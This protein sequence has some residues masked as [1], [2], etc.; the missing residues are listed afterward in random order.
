[1]S[2]LHKPP[3]KSPPSRDPLAQRRAIVEATFAVCAESG[4]PEA[5]VAEIAQRAGGGIDGF[6]ASFADK[7]QA[8][9]EL[10]SIEEGRLLGRVEG[11]CVGVDDPASR[12]ERGL[13]AVL[14]WV[15]D[16]PRDA[17]VCIVESTRATRRIFERR[18][19]TLERLAVLLESNAPRGPVPMPASFGDL[20]VAGVCEVLGH[21]LSTGEGGR[22][23]DLAPE[24]NELLL[25]SYLPPSGR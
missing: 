9:L 14:E 22:V 3:L 24:L 5:T 13:L 19:Q 10:L 1:M 23:I 8:F 12:I 16:S 21:R 2:D 17:R 6:R 18:E 15:D 7:E 20:L 4:Y 11:G 25:G